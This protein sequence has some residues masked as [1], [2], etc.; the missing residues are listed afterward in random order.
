[1][2]KSCIFIL[3]L[4]VFLQGCANLDTID[5]ITTLPSSLSDLACREGRSDV[6]GA[7]P[8]AHD[9]RLALTGDSAPGVMIGPHQPGGSRN[10]RQQA[11]GRGV[12]SPDHASVRLCRRLQL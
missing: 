7:I 12:L 6:V 9:H 10:G 5:R 4:S 2:R 1:M 8:G 11:A 3:L